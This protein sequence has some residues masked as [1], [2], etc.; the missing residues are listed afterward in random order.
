M[1]HLFAPY[2]LSLLAKQ[3]GFNEP[4]FGV[5]YAKEKELNQYK[6]FP[7]SGNEDDF[8]FTKNSN[9][10]E[11]WVTAPLYQQLVDWLRENHNWNIEISYRNSFR[12]Y[13]GILYPIFPRTDASNRFKYNTYYE[14]LNKAL[15]EAFKLI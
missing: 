8:S 2:E 9:L 5:Y 11:T 4:C 6:G 15:E 12:D 13:T 3:K 1:K 14:A 7:D 10:T